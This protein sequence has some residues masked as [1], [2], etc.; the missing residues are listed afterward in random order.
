MLVSSHHSLLTENSFRNLSVNVN[1]NENYLKE[2]LNEVNG[3]LRMGSNNELELEK[4]NSVVEYF[5]VMKN[6]I[7]KSQLKNHRKLVPLNNELIT[8][9]FKFEYTLSLVLLTISDGI[10]SHFEG[11]NEKISE[12]KVMEDYPSPNIIF[13]SINWISEEKT[14]TPIQEKI[15]HLNHLDN[16]DLVKPILLEAPCGE[17]KTLASLIHAEKLFKNNVINKVIFLLPT[18]IT[19]N[20]MFSEFIEDY[21]VP[22]KWMGLYHSEFL[23]FFNSYFHGDEINYSF[24]KYSNLTYSKPF[25]ISTIDHLLLA[26]VNGFKFAPRA[27]GNIVNS[28]IVIDELHYYDY[29]TLS[30]IEVL[31]KILKILKIPHIVMSATIPN[32]IKNRFIQNNYTNIQSSG[33][34]LNNIEKNPF[35]FKFYDETLFEEEYISS[36]LLN[37]IDKNIDK[38]IGIIVNTISTSKLL[39]NNLKEIYPDK[40]ILLYNS[41][42]M[43][44]DRPIKEKLIKCFSKTVS[45]RITE[46]EKNFLNKYDFTSDEKFI[47]IGT[48]VAEISLNMSFDVIISELAPLDALIQR[49]GRLHRTHTYNNNRDCNCSQCKKINGYFEYIFHVFNTGKYCYP[50]FT[51]EDKMDSYKVNIVNN[52]RK[53]LIN[54]PK[55][56]FLNSIDMMNDVYNEN[57]F[58]EEVLDKMDRDKLN[59][60]D[61]I[62]EDLIFGKNPLNHEEENGQT[63][64]Q[65]REINSQ[66]IVVLPIIFNYND[67]DVSAYDFV[68]F[69][70]EN[71]NFKDNSTRKGFN[72]IMNYMISVSNKFYHLNKADSITIMNKTIK[73]IDMRYS[74]ERGLFD[75]EHIYS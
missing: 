49:G 6:F 55:F 72:E 53:V 13:N 54:S 27:F 25:N 42:F 41:Q 43:K 40:Q 50:Y 61:K 56:T 65:T 35:E 45:N 31:C 51:K 63:R 57:S 8:I 20:N 39:F 14:L 74:F 66:S 47:F 70:F 52:T 60:E 12:K 58:D 67:N 34:D 32:F 23:T 9:F 62:R 64:I 16:K 29:Y 73:V 2:L 17:G 18:Q 28:L 5:E 38:N 3:K 75:D 30:L 44:K 69:I 19:S 71:N 48:Q 59:F 36:R 4:F 10:S 7:I 26:L 24:E 1:Y 22:E 46:E 21:N 68:N 37:L 33:H 15:K 11:I